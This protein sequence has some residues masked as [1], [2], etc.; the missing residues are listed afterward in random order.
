[1][2]LKVKSE[3]EQSPVYSDNDLLKAQ[4]VLSAAR[5]LISSTINEGKPELL[6]A[7]GQKKDPHTFFTI[8]LS[9]MRMSWTTD[10]SVAAV[11][12][13]PTSPRGQL[14]LNP[15]VLK[16]MMPWELASVLVHEVYH[17]ILEHL[18]MNERWKKNQDLANISMDVVV[19][20]KTEEI[21][22]RLIKAGRTGIIDEDPS[23]TID[24][25]TYDGFVAAC[26]HF[27]AP[28]PPKGQSWE[29]YF[30]HLLPY[31]QQQ[32]QQQPQGGGQGQGNS[33]YDDL[34]DGSGHSLDEG[35]G[36][37]GEARKRLVAEAVK[38]ASEETQAEGGRLPGNMQAE[39]ENL[40][41]TLRPPVVLENMLPEILAGC[42]TETAY[43]SRTRFN[44]HGT[45]GRLA[46]R[47]GSSLGIVI[48]T[49]GSVNDTEFARAIGIIDDYRQRTGMTVYVLQC[50]YGETMDIYELPSG[51]SPNEIHGRC[52]YGGTFMK[53][54]I[55]AFLRQNNEIGEYEV[56]GI[57]VITDGELAWESE[58]LPQSEIDIPLVYLSS[59]KGQAFKQGSGAAGRVYHYNA[60]DGAVE[61]LYS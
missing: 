5:L 52:G 40:I 58:A 48:D 28:T 45:L 10:V 46:F 20:Q 11:T 55:E 56:G 26:K 43:I 18:W 42:G 37:E 21:G 57:V 30:D 14:A 59:R 8:L 25:V 36:T 4:A 44:R 6:K 50:S 47:P 29:A 7:W 24:P 9:Q 51:M 60:K 3:L 15:K 38:Q 39:I 17:V 16:N 27:G 34:A 2:T 12:Y 41:K 33:P 23:A 53:P 19:N 1:M 54:G 49:S 32:Q 31:L 22:Y 13:S 35:S 61:C